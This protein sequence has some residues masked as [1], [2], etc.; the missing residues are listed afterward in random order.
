MNRTNEDRSLILAAATEL[1]DYL[2]SDV[3][4]WKLTGSTGRL[5]PGNLLLALKRIQ[6]ELVS[7][8]D[9]ELHSTLDTI[10]Q[11]RQK[12][13]SAWQKKINTEIPYRLRLWGNSLEDFIED[14]ALDR[15]YGAQ[16]K[17]RVLVELLSDEVR[18]FRPEWQGTLLRADEK[19][20]KISING[21][22]VWEPE[23]EKE[24]PESKYWYLFVK[25]NEVF[26]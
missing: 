1:D 6:T 2:S 17:N 13:Q 14:G 20:K 11:T 15:S 5:T 18:A 21:P 26:A 19:L 24:F 16:V 25:T 8:S 9:T 3:L 22:F 12:R 10:E 7:E 4:S 23:L